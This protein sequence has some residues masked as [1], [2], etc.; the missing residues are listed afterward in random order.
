[1][2]TIVAIGIVFTAA[3][4]S[5]GPVAGEWRNVDL[6]GIESQPGGC[7]R[8]WLEE[9]LYDLQETAD[10]VMGVYRNIIR[11]A[12]VGPLSFGPNCKAYPAPASNPIA[13]QLRLWSIIG[14]PAGNGAW[15][16]GAEPGI[17]GGDLQLMKTEE[18]RTAVVER[19]GRLVD[20]TGDAANPNDTLVFRPAGSV[21]EAA[22]TALE[23][24]VT[25]LHNGECLDVASALG[26]SREIAVKMCELRE[27]MSSLTGGYRSLTV[28]LTTEFDRVPENFPREA[29]KGW[30]RQHGVFFTFTGIYEKQQVPGNAIVYEDGG[31]WHV[32]FLWL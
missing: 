25:R 24:T 26:A 15:R 18:F 12:P 13:S 20:G 10:K 28:D 27:R 7:V 31:Q 2:R 9:R 17:G 32:A 4:A 1:M 21:P 14:R 5:A 29:S 30:R 11:A 8:V 19:N 16:I 23:R 22:R 6:R 3:L